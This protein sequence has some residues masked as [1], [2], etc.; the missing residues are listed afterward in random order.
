MRS[1][2]TIDLPLNTS[3]EGDPYPDNTK[4]LSIVRSFGWEPL[5]IRAL[6][7]ES[8]KQRRYKELAEKLF[9]DMPEI[10]VEEKDDVVFYGYLADDQTK[11]V[12]TRRVEGQ[13]TFRLLHPVLPRLQ[14]STKKMIKKILDSHMGNISNQTVVL[15]ER[16]FDHIIL[17]GRVIPRPLRET[18][19]TDRK[20]VLL[21]T[22]PV[23][24]LTFLLAIL[25][26]ANLSTFP[27][28]QGTVERLST[29]LIT[30]ALVS[31]VGL[32][33]TYWEISRNRLISWN[34]VSEEK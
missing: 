16:G 1:V 19:R 12:I 31:M 32:I 13:I 25:L 23:V 2:F 26:V 24:L 34:F 29:A 11:F 4:I 28:I 15:Y 9:Q 6:E 8:A 30:T 7:D 27:L 14:A 21:L 20:D 10:A 33:Q 5:E 22:V 3:N 17:N 18:I